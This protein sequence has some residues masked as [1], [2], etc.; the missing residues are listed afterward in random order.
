MWMQPVLSVEQPRRT[1]SANGVGT[2]EPAFSLVIEGIASA[3]E[4]ARAESH[5]LLLAAARFAEAHQFAAIWPPARFLESPAVEIERLAAVAGQIEIRTA[6]SLASDVTSKAPRSPVWVEVDDGSE[7]FKQAA[8]M[9]AHVLAHLLGRS[10]ESVGKDIAL[11]RRTWME[12]G[13]A[14]RGYVSLLVPTLVGEDESVIRAAALHAMQNRL[15]RRP[16]LLRD[17][18]WDFPAFLDAL[19]SNGITLDDFLATR[20]A[21]QMGELIRFA[22][23]RSVST[24]GLIGC[25][26]HCVAFV[27]QLKQIGVDEIAC[28]VDFGWPAHLAQEQLTAL[29]ELRLVFQECDPAIAC[30]ESA[31]PLNG[32]GVEHS[33]IRAGASALPSDRSPR[34]ETEEKL[35]EVW[36]KLLD[37]SEI[38]PADN[39]FDLGGHS[40]LAA[41]AVSEIERAFG[42]RLAIKTLMV[43]S[44]GQ[45][46]LEIQHSAAA[47]RLAQECE[48]AVPDTSPA[49]ETSKR[50]RLATWF[51]NSRNGDRFQDGSQPC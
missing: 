16:S 44:L 23:E 22:A 33:T 47:V 46:A 31:P 1:P 39:F 14:G 7:R 15:R 36:G 25:E 2:H 42:V 24:A 45:V 19:G 27:E 13:H 29:N 50:G 6:V 30:I 10:V 12:A 48:N 21:E 11:Y 3:D 32:H 49:R 38:G 34:N 8:E 5:D 43:N 35:A 51:K 18:V 20:T 4:A 26:D 40:L 9:G 28:L 41:R 37:V 17:A